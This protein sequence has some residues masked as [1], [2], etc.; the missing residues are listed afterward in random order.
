M[1]DPRETWKEMFWRVS[2][3]K[4][5]PLVERDSLPA[6]LVEK[7]TLLNKALTM[8]NSGYI[9]EREK[10]PNPVDLA[11][12]LDKDKKS[13]EIELRS[14]FDIH[15]QQRPEQEPAALSKSPNGIY[16]DSKSK[17]EEVPVNKFLQDLENKKE[18]FEI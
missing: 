2:E 7:P 4:P 12:P 14:D 3:F 17:E 11:E 13:A 18:N 1:I 6:D 9:Q 16:M 5:P 10:K 8:L 15:I